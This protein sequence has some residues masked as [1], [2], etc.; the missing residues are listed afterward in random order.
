VIETLFTLDLRSGHS[1]S[2]RFGVDGERYDLGAYPRTGD[3]LATGGSLHL[4]AGDHS[5]DP[6]ERALLDDWGMTDVLAGGGLGRPRRLAA[7]DLR[8]RGVRGP[9]PRRRRAAAARRP[10]GAAGGRAA[11]RA[12]HR[13]RRA[14][15][16]AVATPPAAVRCC[17]A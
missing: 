9:A 11:P 8:R 5:A 7:R 4:Y 16:P 2:V 12:P 3:L 10:R 6:A 14:R 15:D 1:S 13:Q 17:R